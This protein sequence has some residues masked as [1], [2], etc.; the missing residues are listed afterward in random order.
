MS[1]AIALGRRTVLGVK[2]HSQGNDLECPIWGKLGIKLERS[3]EV[4]WL[5]ALNAGLR[6]CIDLIRKRKSLQI[7]YYTGD[8]KIRVMFE[9]WL[10]GLLKK[11]VKVVCLGH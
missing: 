5:T 9:K 8:R 4:C 1:Q 11:P 3:I 2:R 6:E 10:S 7:C